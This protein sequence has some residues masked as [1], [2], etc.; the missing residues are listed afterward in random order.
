MTTMA[1]PA[2]QAD[3]LRRAGLR[4]TAQRVAVLES[5]AAH[6]HAAVDALHAD[7]LERIPG[8]ALQTVHG[9]VNDLT[10][11]GIAQRVSL[12]GAP[13]ALYEIA[14]R[15]NHH[16]IQCV[17][18]GR[19]EDVPCAVGEAPCLQPSHGHGMRVIEATVTFRAIC[20]DCERNSPA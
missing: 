1:P 7:V 6:P 15:D 8:I 17:E 5:L 10:A 14:A 16:H 11:A 9:V 19:V 4:V 13:S 2:E 3:A 12:P 20:S 18:C